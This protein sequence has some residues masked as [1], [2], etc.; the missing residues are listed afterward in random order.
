MRAPERIGSKVLPVAMIAAL[1]CNFAW[2]AAA[3]PVSSCASVT[4]ATPAG[5]DD[6]CWLGTAG[7][8]EDQLRV[9]E[10]QCQHVS[11]AHLQ[12]PNKV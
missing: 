7:R 1:G 4:Q 2:W 9:V 3:S 6:A 5:R 10:F 12:M 11:L 8:C